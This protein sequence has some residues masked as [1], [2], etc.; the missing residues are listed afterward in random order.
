MRRF[1]PASPGSR[2]VDGEF[3]VP[4]KLGK[5]R[6]NSKSDHGV[7]GDDNKHDSNDTITSSRKDGK[8]FSGN[9]IDFETISSV[10]QNA[11][12]INREIVS[13]SPSC[14]FSTPALQAPANAQC[15]VSNEKSELRENGSVK[16]RMSRGPSL[17]DSTSRIPNE[18]TIL[19]PC[20]KVQVT[21]DACEYGWGAWTSNWKI[22]GEWSP[23][24]KT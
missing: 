20:R 15:F 24:E 12:K 17:M 19:K 6:S 4:N 18:S 10:S 5:D 1:D 22:G 9:Q 11:C 8:H 3:G 21:T 16:Q 13:S 23:E 14:S 7:Y 2:K